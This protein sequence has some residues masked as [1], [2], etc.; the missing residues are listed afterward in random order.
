MSDLIASYLGTGSSSQSSQSELLVEAYKLT[1]QPK[2]DAL[3][4]KTK[5]LES[6]QVFFNSLNAKLNA[7][8][9]KMDGF[10]V[11]DPNAMFSTRKVSV[12]NSTYFT[13]TADSDALLGS[14]TAIVKRL[15]AND[16]LVS[17]QLTLSDTAA[18]SGISGDQTI[19]FTINGEAQD[20]TVNFTGSETAEQAMTKISDAINKDDDLDIT[21]M[22]VK[23]TAETG[24]LTF[25]SKETGATD[26]V[27][28][29]DSDVLGRLGITQA[30][31]NPDSTARTVMN[32][33][34]AG[35]Q[36]ADYTQLTSEMVVGGIT[37]I[38]DSNAV[39]DALPGV[40]FNLLNVHDAEDAAVNVKTESDP[41]A[42]EN[43]ITPLLEA[44][45]DIMN[46]ASN[47]KTMVR[48][49]T[50]ISGLRSRLRGLP[51]QEITSVSEGN[52]NRLTDI[53]IKI[54]SNGLL[55]IDDH[56]RLAEVLIEDPDL[57]ANLFTSENGFIAKLEDATSTLKG[58]DGL[59]KARKESIAEQIDSSE[60][61]TD[62][63]E[64]RIEARA[65]LLR[66]EYEDM[67]AVMLEAQNQYSYLF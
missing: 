23:D 58:T 18:F 29:A 54:D 7:L 55:S 41:T 63:L 11:E 39:D 51:S 49:D 26:R 45:N 19:S 37:I 35:Y 34:D 43:L 24:R 60:T 48:S 47:N 31:L 17:K 40:T 64:A 9:S 21:A 44:F 27:T 1:E 2:V 14:T 53:G 36:K 12:S 52:P 32:D 61:R 8:V 30:A 50:A 59:I 16:S 10:D 42:V 4:N 6:K 38:R 28:F 62:E 66:K 25:T 13:A 46:Y 22:L 65:E 15:A 3:N 56:D 20:I 33:T 57:V 5:E 67:L